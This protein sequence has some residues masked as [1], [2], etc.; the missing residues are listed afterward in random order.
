MTDKM[1]ALLKDIDIKTVTNLDLSLKS[2]TDEDIAY[3][4]TLEFPALEVLYLSFNNLITP[5][6]LGGCKKLKF[7]DLRFNK[8]TTPPKPDGCKELE[9]LIVSY[10]YLTTPPKLENNKKIKYL[11]LRFNNLITKE[12]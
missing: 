8:L 6:K 3:F 2:L 9:L 10:N 5:P 12:N 1:K 4:N 11:N 7:L